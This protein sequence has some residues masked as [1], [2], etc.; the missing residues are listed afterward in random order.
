MCCLSVLPWCSFLFWMLLLSHIL[1]TC[2]GLLLLFCTIPVL[3][4]C[5]ACP[6]LITCL[7]P[8]CLNCVCWLS[9]Y[10]VPF[11]SEFVTYLFRLFFCLFRLFS[12]LF[13]LLSY[14]FRLFFYLFRP[15]FC[16][17]SLFFCLFC[18]LFCLFRPFFC[19]FRLFFCLFRLFNCLF[20]PFLCLI[21]LFFCLF[22][23]IFCLSHVFLL[24]DHPAL[25]AWLAVV[26]SAAPLVVLSMAILSLIYIPAT[27]DRGIIYHD[28]GEGGGY[29]RYLWGLFTLL[30]VT[31]CQ[32]NM[33]C[34]DD[35]LTIT[36]N[37]GT[38]IEAQS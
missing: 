36:N 2:L 17:F 35:P 32:Q 38:G 4:A 8:A 20:R 25:F 21:R 27:S 1:S 5:F 37:A 18:L 28:A 24:A 22:R 19:I 6:T 23:L 34:A 15:L 12:C 33:Y 30:I 31:L 10:T 11:C 9:S 13:R 7:L 14:L 3:P 29:F 16:L 26:L